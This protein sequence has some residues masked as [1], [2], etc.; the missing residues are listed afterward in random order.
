MQLEQQTTIRSPAYRAQLMYDQM[1][2]DFEHEV[3]YFINTGYLFST[4]EYFIMG[5]RL[6][7]AWFIQMAV[8]EG[9]MKKFMELML[10]RLPYIKWCR[11]FKGDKRVRCF[12]TEQL[13]RV[14]GYERTK[15]GQNDAVLHGRWRQSA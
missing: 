15:D 7:D 5:S 8:G 10:F 4:P 13:E 14:I 11:F 9:C 6:K 12:K 3:R 2:W 1:G